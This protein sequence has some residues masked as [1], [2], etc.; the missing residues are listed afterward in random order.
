[1]LPPLKS[2]IASITAAA[3]RALDPLLDLVAAVPPPRPDPEPRNHCG[4][5]YSTSEG[6]I[7]QILGPDSLSSLAA[8]RNKIISS[9]DG[10]QSMI[11]CEQWLQ[12]LIH[13]GQPTSRILDI[14]EAVQKRATD[15][16]LGR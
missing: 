8:T 2:T 15:L 13:P 12:P 7:Q 4:I 9:S 10:E 5:I 6:T 11:I 3:D 14:L 16:V 1:V